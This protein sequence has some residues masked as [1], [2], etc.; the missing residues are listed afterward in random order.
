MQKVLNNID[1]IF[2]FVIHLLPV[3]FLFVY[4]IYDSERSKY[5][6]IQFKMN[7]TASLLKPVILS[8]WWIKIHS[9]L[10]YS[11]LFISGLLNPVVSHHKSYFSFELVVY[12]I[13]VNRNNHTGSCRLG[14][15]I[16]YVCLFMCEFVWIF[17]NMYIMY[18]YVSY[19]TKCIH[20]TKQTYCMCGIYVRT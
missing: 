1:H 8:N 14:Y 5:I 20:A 6:F 15:N 4:F 13:Y 19:C 10:F 11:I 17:M 16:L 9:I 12:E 7:R 2:I 3:H 18:S